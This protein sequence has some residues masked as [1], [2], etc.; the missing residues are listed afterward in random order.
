MEDSKYTENSGN[1]VLTVGEESYMC[2]E[3]RPEQTLWC[4]IGG[5]GNRV[6]RR[7]LLCLG[8]QR[9][10]RVYINRHI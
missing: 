10:T 3:K 8:K 7:Y 4:L 9:N 1:E 2:Q 6:N 5:G